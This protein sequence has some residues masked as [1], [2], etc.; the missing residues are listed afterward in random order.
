[1][2]DKKNLITKAIENVKKAKETIEQKMPIDIVAIFIKI[3]R[4]FRQN[5]R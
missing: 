2:L 1:M 5:Y 3:F 4:G